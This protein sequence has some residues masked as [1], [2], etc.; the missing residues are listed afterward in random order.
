MSQYKL[1]YFAVRALGEPIR[2][3]FA[4]K[5]IKFEDDRIIWDYPAWFQMKKKEFMDNGAQIPIL[6]LPN[7]KT[8]NQSIAIIRYLAAENGLMGD[9][10]WAEARNDQ[11]VHMTF[12]LF[13]AWRGRF[14]IP[15][16]ESRQKMKHPGLLP[17][18]G[19]DDMFNICYSKIN[20][21]LEESTGDLINGNKLTYAD[22]WLA[23][24]LNIWDDPVTGSGPVVLPGLPSPSQEDFYLNLT[25]KYPNLR[26]HK[27]TVMALPQIK[28]WIEE[29]PKTTA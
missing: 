18:K 29:R 11:I 15:N 28:K 16:E 4:Y 5:G 1:T 27:Q 21:M 9:S 25:E 6:T 12:D 22:L 7:G 24:F 3:L 19:I 8:I 20:Q 26:K 10:S 2:W 23:S 17:G 13:V 14:F